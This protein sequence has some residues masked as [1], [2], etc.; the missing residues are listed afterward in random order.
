MEIHGEKYGRTGAFWSIQSPE[1]R[2]ANPITE[3]R[4]VEGKHSAPDTPFA[5]APMEKCE[6]LETLRR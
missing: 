1:M 4:V 5:P 2:R 6:P 3:G